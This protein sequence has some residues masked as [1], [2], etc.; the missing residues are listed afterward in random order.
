M[1]ILEVKSLGKAFNWIKAIDD[2]S[3]SID[4]W[5]VIW[6]IWPNWSWKSTLFNLLTSVIG[7]D[8]WEVIFNWADITSKK[9]HEISGLWIVRTFQDSLSLL[10]MTV[11]EN[12]DTAFD[13][14]KDISLF[15]VFFSSKHMNDERWYHLTKIKKMLEEVWI[16]DKLESFAQDLSYWQCKL[17]EVLK[18][19]A[20]DK[21]LILLDEPFSGLFPEMI[22][23]IKSL[24]GKLSKKWKTII[25]IEHNMNLI[26]EICD[27]VIVLDAGRCIAE[28]KFDEVKKEKI[29]IESY[30]GK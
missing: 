18:V 23:L 9:T 10:Q 25:L 27:R 8:N 13:Y 11:K 20:S 22:R 30:L 29:V 6:L 19:F 14:T 17:L 28:W 26:S 16:S 15:N 24:I 3:F 12:L 21:Q 5:E 1:K 2:L 4:P 7:S